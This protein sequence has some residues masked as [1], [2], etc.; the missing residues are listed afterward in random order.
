MAVN[1][2]HPS[3]DARIADWQ[4]CRDVYEGQSAVVCRDGGKRYL[5]PTTGQLIDMRERPEIGRANYE[6][7]RDRALLSGFL[8]DAIDMFLGLLWHRPTVFELGPLESVFGE[9]RPATG[10]GESLAQLLRRMHVEVMTTGRLG[11]LGDLPAEESQSP[12]PY[13]ELYETEQIVNWNDGAREL[14]RAKLNLVVLDESAAEMQP[15][16]SWA[17]KCYHRVL[18]LGTLAGLESS[19]AYSV[20]RFENNEAFDPSRAEQ[21]NVRRRALDEIPFVFVSTKSLTTRIEPPPLISLARAVLALYRMDADY[22]QH[23]HMCGQDTLFTRGMSEEQVKSVGAGAHIHSDG[24]DA[25][26][27]FIGINSAGLAETRQAIENDRTLCAKKAGELLADNSAQRESG[28][29]LTLRTGRKGASLVDVAQMCAEGLQR[30]LRILAKWLG[31]SPAEVETIKVIPNTKFGTPVFKS[32]EM[33]ALV[34]AYVLGAPITLKSIHEW[35]VAHGYT[36][37]TWDEMIAE[38]RSEAELLGDLM[39]MPA[40]DPSN[41][42]GGDDAGGSE[43]GNAAA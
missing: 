28:D 11:L 1:S 3:Y 24:P 32:A 9:N 39:P 41:D 17:P 15:D 25:D 30:M 40:P 26:A 29:A 43:E 7:Y 14:G 2:H 16:L 35:S 4:A 37:L 33:K 13:I 36:T 23:I 8:S 42:D 38:K 5:P 12:T 18:W 19:G 34:E 22:R 10:Q 20:A 31:A 21:P 27:K 6:A